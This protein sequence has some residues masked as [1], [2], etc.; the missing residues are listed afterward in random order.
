MSTVIAGVQ[1]IDGIQDAPMAAMDVWIEFDRIS[2][3]LPAGQAPHAAADRIIDG[4]GSTV[5]PGLIDCHVHYTLDPSAT[6][7][8]AT[9]AS[10]FRTATTAVREA[11]R[12]LLAG[13][14]TARSAGA[15]RN[16][17]FELRDAIDEGIVPGPR[18]IAAGLIIGI[19]GGHG[20]LLGHEADSRVELIKAVRRQVRDGADVIKVM[21]SEAAMLTTTGVR[22]GRKVAGRPEM[23]EAEIRTVVEEAHSLDVKVL[24]HA[25]GSESVA[26]AARAGVDSVEHAFLADENALAQLRE[27]NVTLVPTLTV[28]DVNRSASGMTVEQRERQRLIEDKHRKSC[29]LAIAMGIRVAAGTDV[30]DKGIFS[31][32]LSR[33]IALLADHGLPAMEAIKAGTSLA[34]DLVGVGDLTGTIEERKQADL[35]MVSGNPVTDLSTLRSPT[36]VMKGGEICGDAGV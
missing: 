20:H 15:Q 36:L 17:D 3:I 31:N 11:R 7:H 19:T 10:D 28:T 16:L 9:A 25:Q 2:R 35:I 1:L 24:A 27:H 12:A 5:L 13:I 30:G 6:E 14:T 32:L 22:P 34:A 23:S 4:T 26:N 8:V 29:E 33:E 21:A 18:L